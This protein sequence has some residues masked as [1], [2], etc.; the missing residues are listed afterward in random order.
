MEDS[1]FEMLE[2]EVQDLRRVFLALD[3]RISGFESWARG[4]MAG[5]ALLMAVTSGLLFYVVSQVDALRDEI[6]AYRIASDG[7][8]AELR[9]IVAELRADIRHL[10]LSAGP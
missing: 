5:L 8:I 7:Q 1:R 3:A 6:Q 4:F 10:R 9:E 2:A